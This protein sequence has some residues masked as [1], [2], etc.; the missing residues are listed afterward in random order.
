MTKKKIKVGLFGVGRGMFLWKY[1]KNAE[2]AELV[3]ICDKNET[4]IEKAKEELAS[5]LSRRKNICRL[6]GTSEAQQYLR[7]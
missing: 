1:C 3:A 5:S 4:A 7:I 2:N 6:P